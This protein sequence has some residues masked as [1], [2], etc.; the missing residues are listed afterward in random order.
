MSTKRQVESVKYPHRPTTNSPGLRWLFKNWL[1]C[2]EG[3]ATNACSPIGSEALATAHNWTKIPWVIAG[4]ST[5]QLY[6]VWVSIIMPTR[7]MT[8]AILVLLAWSL[9]LLLPGCLDKDL[10]N[11]IRRSSA[12]NNNSMSKS[13]NCHSMSLHQVQLTQC[14]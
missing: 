10:S 11:Q 12:W 13:K 5:Y 7:G 14:L 6:L 1:I 2:K 4:L 3:C 9:L 8:P